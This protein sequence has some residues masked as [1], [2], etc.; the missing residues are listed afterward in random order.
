MDCKTVK[1]KMSSFVDNELKGDE[2]TSFI[3]HLNNCK[4][5]N[6]EYQMLRRILEIANNVDEKELPQGYHSEL[7]TKI[8]ILDD[9][10]QDSFINRL[11][12]R[13][14]MKV[15]TACACVAILFCAARYYQQS[16][17]QNF[18]LQEN[19]GI[20]SDSAGEASIEDMSLNK[21]I[22]TDKEEDNIN[23]AAGVKEKTSEKESK[24]DTK[25]L[26]IQNEEVNDKNKASVAVRNRKGLTG[27]KKSGFHDSR[28]EQKAVY[29]NILKEIMNEDID[30]EKQYYITVDLNDLT[31]VNEE[32]KITIIDDITEG[33]KDIEKT[34]DNEVVL[35]VISTTIRADN[36]IAIMAS[37]SSSFSD[38]LYMQFIIT[39]ENSK[40]AIKNSTVIQSN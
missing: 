34:D 36:E 26:T 37:R 25:V 12:G 21:D 15:A 28:A 33:N 22:S 6:E 39:K 18:M 4:E 35:K 20:V 8:N 2:Y 9:K 3:K 24:A 10:K 11:F 30:T 19:N 31:L 17:T 32:D 23:I 14:F 38:D 13:G 1:E 27:V 40:W 7:M 16:N 29:T 5:C